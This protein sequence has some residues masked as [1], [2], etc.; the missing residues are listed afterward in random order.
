MFQQHMRE[1][2]RRGVTLIELLVVVSIIT[3]LVALLLPAVHAAREASRAA[4]CQ[5][6]LRQFGVGLQSHAQ[7]H[8]VLC[9]G[10]FDWKRDGCV[11]EIG[12][13]ADLV[14]AG[15]PA[16]KMLCPS[17]ECR[18]GA[19]YNDLLDLDVT[20]VPSFVDLKGR[21]PATRPDGTLEVSPCR[22]IVEESLAPGSDS[23][24][25]LVEESVFKQHF[26]TNYTAS[27]YLVRSGVALDGS[28][29]LVEKASGGGKSLLSRQCTFGPL[30][31]GLADKPAKSASSFVPLLACGGWG[32][33]LT[34]AV[35]P[36]APGTPLAA[37]FTA[38]PVANPS[39]DAPTFSAGT[40]RTG[41]SGWWAAWED[42]LQDYRGFAP[43]HRGACNILF[44]DGSVRGYLDKNDDGLLNNGFE[45][46]ADNGF[47]NDEVELPP[48]EVASRWTLGRQ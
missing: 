6:N 28:G 41:P 45:A 37:P 16:G 12:W 15:I 2:N 22:Q 14:K 9:S 27:W 40:P 39:M 1:A 32:G 43:V 24:R 31:Q 21:A 34:Q 38:G 33:E 17:N 46:T 19:T 44:A 5:S 4:N 47:A 23:R 13:V 26:N 3:L 11:T 7:F 30:S 42:T 25:A 29:N 20:S 10:A 35:G 8:G 18:L 36:H 48:E